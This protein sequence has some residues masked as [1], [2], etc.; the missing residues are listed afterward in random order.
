MCGISGYF[1]ET[2]FN[3]H[4]IYKMIKAQHHRG[5]DDNGFWTNNENLALG[6]N[7]LSIQDLS[8]NARQ[9]MISH[10][11]NVLVFNNSFLKHIFLPTNNI[12]LFK[13]FIFFINCFFFIW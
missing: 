11:K 7:R 8:N 12:L 6:H 4:S 13:N 2:N 5:P 1:S 3:I 10:Q 9:P